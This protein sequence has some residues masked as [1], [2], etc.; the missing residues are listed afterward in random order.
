MTWLI[1]YAIIGFLVCVFSYRVAKRNKVDTPSGP[2]IEVPLDPGGL[3][4]MALVFFAFWPVV[5]PLWVWGEIGAKK[6]REK[7]EKRKLLESIKKAK[8][9]NYGLSMDQQIDKLR[10][11][12]DELIQ[13]SEIKSR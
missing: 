7:E 2:P 1:A 8:N 10:T 5:L 3:V 9:P 11:L 12:H 13:K 4:F 6:L